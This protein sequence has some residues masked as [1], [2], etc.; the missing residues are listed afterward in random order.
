MTSDGTSILRYWCG[1]IFMP[2][3]CRLPVTG[4][5]N[6]ISIN[7]LAV[8]YLR[9]GGDTETGIYFDDQQVLKVNLGIDKVEEA[10]NVA[11]NSP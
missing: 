7:P 11:L 1:R 5:P 6:T 4:L 3:M 9:P 8:R 2:K 10:L